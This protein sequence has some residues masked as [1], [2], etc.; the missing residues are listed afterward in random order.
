MFPYSPIFQLSLKYF[1]VLS[2]IRKK[3]AIFVMCTKNI[4]ICDAESIDSGL[5]LTKPVVLPI[6]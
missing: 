6:C 3:Y 2:Q 1:A 5:E 4:I